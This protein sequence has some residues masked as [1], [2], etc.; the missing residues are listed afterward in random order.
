MRIQIARA[1]AP[2]SRSR[3]SRIS[4]AAWFVNVMARIS[5][6]LH[7]DGADQVRD[8][9]GEDARLAGARAGDHE[10]R[11]F[12]GQHGLP[13]GGVQVGEIGLRR[14]DR[15]GADRSEEGYVRWRAARGISIHRRP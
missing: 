14:G 12:G 7:A 8:A 3:R 15:H 6:G 11:A 5:F 4:F 10:Q 13:L 9:V 1:P 2:S